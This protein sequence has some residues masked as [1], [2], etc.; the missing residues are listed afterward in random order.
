MRECSGT[1]QSALGIQAD[2]AVA[3]LAADCARSHDSRALDSRRKLR[4]KARPHGRAV[5]SAQSDDCFE[6]ELLVAPGCLAAPVQPVLAACWART[7][8]CGSERSDSS[9]VAR[10]GASRQRGSR[11]VLHCPICWY[12]AVQLPG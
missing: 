10:S 1:E 8:G 12:L 4:T 6:T 5:G 11:A 2:A 3:G 9:K 7:S